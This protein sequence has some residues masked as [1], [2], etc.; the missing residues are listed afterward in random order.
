MKLRILLSTSVLTLLL[1][2]NVQAQ[3]VQ[4]RA[5]SPNEVII[6]EQTMHIRVFDAATRKSIP[7]TV[8][9]KGL[10]PRKTIVMENMTD[11]IFPIRTYRLYTVSC[12]IPGYMLYAQKFWPDEAERHFQ[13]VNMQPLAVGLKTDIRDITFLGSKTEIYHKSKPALDELIEFMTVNPTI[14]ISIIGHVNGPDNSQTF[15]FYEEASYNRAAAVREYLVTAGI[16][17]SRLSVRG[18]GNTEMIYPDPITEWQN[19]ANRRIEIQI[20][21]L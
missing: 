7:G 10:N 5:I 21:S 17:G 4:E 14:S 9:V 1:C 8:N 16:D 20:T 19:E 18:A 2:G 12:V 6:E 11:T 15:E 13:L 3:F